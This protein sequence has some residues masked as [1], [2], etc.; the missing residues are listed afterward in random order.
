MQDF[1]ISCPTRI[2]FGDGAIAELDGLTELDGGRVVLV[3]GGSGGASRPVLE[4]LRARGCEV[5]EIAVPREP[6]VATVNA[7]FARTAPNETDRNPP[8]AVIACGG[9]SVID[10]AKALAFCLEHAA[11]LPDDPATLAPA[12][13]DRP[14]TLP[15]IAIPTTAGTGAEV[16]ANAVLSSGALK[17]SLRG[18][19]L[20]AS[21]AIVDPALART[22]PR[23]VVVGSGLDA[24]VQTIEAHTSRFA[25][26][27]S[28]ALT[29]PN[30]ARGARALR[31][32]VEHD[33]RA[34]WTTLAWVSLSSGLALANSGLGAAHGLAA[35]LGARLDAPHGLLCGRLIGPVLRQ[36]R[37]RAA[38][39]SDAFDRI[40]TAIETL[41]EVFPPQGEAD[42][43]S[44]FQGWLDRH[45]VPRLRDY[46]A[47]PR[48]FD[49]DAEA[50]A[51]ASSSRKNALPL[52]APD[53]RTI[54][55]AAY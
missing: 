54:L 11:P 53:F 12:L 8:A 21:L 26:P 35:V 2:R 50:A 45:E 49:D 24:L 38:L 42:D 48:T 17:S 55:D 28:D 41:A 36:N 16:T 47:D 30:L 5:V 22:A 27:F 43:L 15:L 6:T 13:L 51:A 4:R 40:E 14:R 33:D 19:G 3:R 7:A 34:A 9:G 18:A 46:G 25:T 10:A 44:G 31:R 32:V 52:R 23:R 37:R 29:T 39:G 20:H 1:A